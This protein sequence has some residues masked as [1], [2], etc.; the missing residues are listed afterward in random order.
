MSV[1]QLH[2]NNCTKYQALSAC[3]VFEVYIKLNKA[4]VLEMYYLV[5]E[6]KMRVIKM[7]I[8]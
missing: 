6:L 5:V 3:S 1:I 2:F 8:A 4:A 7:T